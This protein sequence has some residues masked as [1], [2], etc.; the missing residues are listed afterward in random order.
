M[1]GAAQGGWPHKGSYGPHAACREAD[2]WT[3]TVKEHF[4]DNVAGQS[5]LIHEIVTSFFFSR[6]NQSA[7]F[8][9][10]QD[11]KEK[12]EAQNLDSSCAAMTPHFLI[13]TEQTLNGK[14]V[15]SR[16]PAMFFLIPI[17]CS[18]GSVSVTLFTILF[19]GLGV[20]A[21]RDECLLF[22]VCWYSN[23]SFM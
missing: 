8:Q 4:D 3:N 20:A 22:A 9:L 18:K 10:E 19:W 6:L 14:A 12:Y 15:S 23:W 21:V 7:K 5:I 2:R 1:H 13:N 16:W 11:L 17:Q